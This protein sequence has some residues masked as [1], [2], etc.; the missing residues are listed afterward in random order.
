ML[1]SHL[2]NRRRLYNR[3][4]RHARFAMNSATFEFETILRARKVRQDAK[5][6][7]RA[8]DWQQGRAGAQLIDSDH[9]PIRAVA[10]TAIHSNG[11]VEAN[12]ERYRA[13]LAVTEAIVSNRELS[14]LFQE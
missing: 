8:H 2:P 11:Q 9:G 10:M 5:I 13:L 12:G 6:E 4:M 7:V 1:L 3:F 14:T